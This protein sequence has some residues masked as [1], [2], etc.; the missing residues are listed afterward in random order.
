MYKSENI[1]FTEKYRP[2][3][4]KRII[5]DKT[6]TKIFDSILET[7]CFPNMLLYGPPGTGKTTTV[8][9]ITKLY[10]QKFFEYRKDLIIHLNASD[11]RGIDMIRNQI[12]TFAKTNCLFQ[13]GMKFIILDEVDHMTKLAQQS[14]Q[15]LLSV[16]TVNVRFCLMCNYISR[17]EMTLKNELVILRFNNLTKNEICYMLKDICCRENIIPHYKLLTSLIY[18][19]KSDIRSMLNYIQNNGNDEFEFLNP[20]HLDYITKQLGSDMIINEIIAY[21]HELSE[22]TKNSVD[23]ILNEYVRYVLR[24]MKLNELEMAKI[25]EVCKNTIR[26]QMVSIDYR[27]SYFL[28]NMR[29]IFT[30]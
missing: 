17:I 13:K 4:Y 22:T 20:N 24:E 12:Q 14:L 9:N 21:L 23:Y 30:R 3:E 11:D 26:F 28:Y 27:L 25:Y 16:N 7:G 1:P 2:N 15:Y 10:L 8:I 6:N 29:N 5:L 19:Y 18:R